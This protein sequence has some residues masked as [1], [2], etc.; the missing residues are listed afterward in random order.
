M[1]SDGAV[2]NTEQN[3]QRGPAS[4]V[5]AAGV[6]VTAVRRVLDI[7]EA[8]ERIGK[9]LSLTDLA[10]VTGIPKSSCHAIVSTLI[11]RGYLYSLSRPRA[12]YPTRRVFDVAREIHAH[13]PFVERVMPLLERLRDASRETVILGKRQGDAVI[14][15]QVVESTNPIR[16]SARPG[17]F[18]P[19]HSSSIGK[20]LLGSLKEADARAQIAQWPLAAVT[21][22]T[23]TDPD[24]LLA[25]IV[26]S[27]KRGYFVTR[28]ENVADV[29]AVSAFV[30]VH[31][32]TLAIAIAG[33][34]H[35][36]EHNVVECAQA[37][38]ATCSFIAR[39]MAG[40]AGGAGA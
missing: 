7:L 35:R 24:A 5:P 1:N 39:Q 33:P 40:A 2:P 23:I 31:A 27:R 19:L 17:E 11:A 12:L 21:P 28:G 18:K 20:A 8:F 22:A 4:A 32:E 25:D 36:M 30:S 6:A 38:V 29:W 14:Y 10:E 37:L 34:R 26:H 15:L 9:P 13:D 3:G 16:Y